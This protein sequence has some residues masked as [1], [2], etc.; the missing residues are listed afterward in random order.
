M[1]HVD[2]IRA[3]VGGRAAE[4]DDGERAVGHAEFVSLAALW[5]F[6]AVSQKTAVAVW[7]SGIIIL[8]Y[9]LQMQAGTE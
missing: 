1:G 5:H 6:A 8:V 9:E 2:E 7:Q 4:E 3:R